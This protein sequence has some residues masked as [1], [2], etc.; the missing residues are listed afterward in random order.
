MLD[1]ESSPGG[2]FGRMI[3]TEKQADRAW[4]EDVLIDPRNQPR[5]AGAVS[6]VVGAEMI[7]QQ[8]FFRRHS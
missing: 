6:V 3:H 1:Q 2:R 7:V 8:S 4:V 5:G